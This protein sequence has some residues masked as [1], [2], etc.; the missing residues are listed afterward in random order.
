MGEEWDGSF[1]NSGIVDLEIGMMELV[2]WFSF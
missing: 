1:L 2:S